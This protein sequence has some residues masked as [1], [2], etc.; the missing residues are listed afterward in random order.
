[1][2][3]Q[4]ITPEIDSLFNEFKLEF[5]GSIYTAPLQKIY[6]GYVAIQRGNIAPDFSGRTLEGKLISL[7]DFMTQLIQLLQLFQPR[8]YLH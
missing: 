4:A 6:D 1:M 3:S 2:D 8:Y 5:E 7:T